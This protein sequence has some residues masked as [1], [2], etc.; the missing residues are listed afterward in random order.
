M[1]TSFGVINDNIYEIS[2]WHQL[3]NVPSD[4]ADVKLSVNDVNDKLCSGI[5]ISIYNSISKLNY[6][7]FFISYNDTKIISLSNFVVSTDYAISLLNSFGFAVKFNA[8]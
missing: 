4:I 3:I 6:I 2:D 1:K 5:S 8:V 7:T